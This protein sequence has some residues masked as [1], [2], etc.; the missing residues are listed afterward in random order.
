[1]CKTLRWKLTSNISGNLLW[2]LISK[3][4]AMKF[5]YNELYFSI[6]IYISDVRI[7]L[8]QRSSDW[9]KRNIFFF[10]LYVSLSVSLSV[11]LC[12]CLYCEYTLV[13]VLCNHVCI[14]FGKPRFDNE[15]LLW[16]LSPLLF[17]NKP[18]V[19]IRECLYI[20]QLYASQ[21]TKLSPFIYSHMLF[22]E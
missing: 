11:C 12:V 21:N 14:H 8:K 9:F 22:S 20:S 7:P 6:S 19:E 13:N 18:V 16:F 3:N 15:C 1:M 5:M 4:L 17:V 10:C 2:T